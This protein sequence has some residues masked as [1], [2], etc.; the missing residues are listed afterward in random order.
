MKNTIALSPAAGKGTRKQKSKFPLFAIK[1]G[2]ASFD[3]RT[4]TTA[5]CQR[6]PDAAPGRS[7]SAGGK[8]SDYLGSGRN[9]RER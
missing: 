1:V 3:G 7:P 9:C 6:C 8:R 5:G 4:G 2:V